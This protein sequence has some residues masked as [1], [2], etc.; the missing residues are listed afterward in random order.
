MGEPLDGSTTTSLRTVNSVGNKRGASVTASV[1]NRGGLAGCDG[2]N[3]DGGVSLTSLALT[4]V[5]TCLPGDVISSLELEFD[6]PFSNR[7]E[8]THAGTTTDRTCGDALEVSQKLPAL[9]GEDVC[10]EIMRCTT[11]GAVGASTD[12][13]ED[14]L[15]DP[16][17]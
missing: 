17:G 16:R 2:A 3:R 12:R 1:T 13:G 11:D 7:G 5:A 14:C 9:G 4:G 6:T 15:G 10:T 8:L